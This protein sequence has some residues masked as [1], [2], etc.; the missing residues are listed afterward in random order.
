MNKLLCYI[1]AQNYLTRVPTQNIMIILFSCSTVFFSRI[2]KVLK[3]QEVYYNHYYYCWILSCVGT[4][5]SD[6]K[7]TYTYTHMYIF[8]VAVRF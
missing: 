8:V 1:Y 7:Y 4:F 3:I 6:T 2:S 5:M